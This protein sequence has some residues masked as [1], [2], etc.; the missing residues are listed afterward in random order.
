M[1]CPPV[2]DAFKGTLKSYNCL[3]QIN[4]QKCMVQIFTCLLNYVHSPTAMV[5]V[6]MWYVLRGNSVLYPYP[7]EKDIETTPN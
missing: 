4:E 1:G 5:A 6:V 3:K 7:P 2:D